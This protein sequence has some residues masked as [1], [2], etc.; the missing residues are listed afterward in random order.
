MTTATADVVQ[1]LHEVLSES[2]AQDSDTVIEESRISKVADKNANGKSA[3]SISWGSIS[4]KVLQRVAE[5][6]SE[7]IDR[8]YFDL[9]QRKSKLEDE[10]GD[11][12]LQMEFDM[13]AYKEVCTVA[14]ELEEKITAANARIEKNQVQIAALKVNGDQLVYVQSYPADNSD[15]ISSSSLDA[16]SDSDCKPG[17]GSLVGRMIVWARE[18]LTSKFHLFR[19]TSKFHLTGKPTRNTLSSTLPKNLNRRIQ[20]S[21]WAG[22]TGQG[23][24]SNISKRRT[25]TR[26]L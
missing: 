6:D 19:L 20:A 3:D 18:R 24:I 4:E 22:I 13:M 16:A 15:L 1:A 8:L 10:K 5:S 12:K 11:L 23:S 9:L 7:T 2:S 17:R 26:C 25:P 21:S 14:Q